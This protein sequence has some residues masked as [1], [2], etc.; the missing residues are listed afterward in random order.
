VLVGEAYAWQN[1]YTNT[2]V[3]SAYAVLILAVSLLATWFYLRILRVR[4]ETLA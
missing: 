3:A 2:G 1:D 4:E